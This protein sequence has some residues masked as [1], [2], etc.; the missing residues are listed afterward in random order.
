MEDCFAG[1][2]S[3]KTFIK[4]ASAGKS[5]ARHAACSC[6]SMMFC[7]SLRSFISLISK[8]SVERSCEQDAIFFHAAFNL[9]SW[10][11]K[12]LLIPTGIHMPAYHPDLP[13][14]IPT[15]LPTLIPPRGVIMLK[16]ESLFGIS[17]CLHDQA[18]HLPRKW[19]RT[20]QHLGEFWGFPRSRSLPLRNSTRIWTD[21]KEEIRSVDHIWNTP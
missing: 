18:G 5:F 6:H 12:A 13:P 16:N 10:L 4:G 3:L 17:K 21:I 15:S 20:M 8:Y 14:S 2:H 11:E 1:L 9:G 7:I 19:G